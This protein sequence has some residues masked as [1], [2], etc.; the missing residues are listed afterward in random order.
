[1]KKEGNRK[2]R[3][4]SKVL[5]TSIFQE[6]EK[7][8]ED[9]SYLEQPSF[10]DV[11]PQPE[12][13]PVEEVSKE[14]ILEEQPIKK[15]EEAALVSS[16]EDSKED[17][18]PRKKKSSK[19]QPK[20]I[21][22]QEVVPTKEQEENSVPAL[23]MEV[24]KEPKEEKKKLTRR[25]KKDTKQTEPIV[26]GEEE[27]ETEK[28][29]L[30]EV[31]PEVSLLESPLPKEKK[32]PA[33]R[34][35][36][37]KKELEQTVVIEDPKSEAIPEIISVP[38]EPKI[39]KPIL[40]PLETHFEPAMQ[41][42]VIEET[43]VK[44]KKSSKKSK[45]AKKE[46]LIQPEVMEPV[47]E[48]QVLSSESSLGVL[49][50][51][52]EA[53]VQPETKIKK[54]SSKRSRKDSQPTV[55]TE[56]PKQEELEDS[57]ASSEPKL[58]KS[59]LEV[60]PEAESTV[61]TIPEVKP[62]KRQKK[63]K[64]DITPETKETPVLQE[65]VTSPSEKKEESKEENPKSFSFSKLLERVEEGLQRLEREEQEKEQQL[66]QLEEQNTKNSEDTPLNE[67]P[68]DDEIE[69]L[70]VTENKESE[71]VF[72]AVKEIKQEPSP[73]EDD[74]EILE[75]E[76]E[77]N[78]EIPKEPIPEVEVLE[79]SFSPKENKDLP[80]EKET[81]SVK[82]MV[83][84]SVIPKKV[85]KKEKKHYIT[86]IFLFLLLLFVIFLPQ[87]SEMIK[88]QTREEKVTSSSTPKKTGY[89][90][91][92]NEKSLDDGTYQVAMNVYYVNNQL[93]KITGR[94]VTT[95]TSTPVVTNLNTLQMSCL[96]YQVAMGEDGTVNCI[97]QENSQTTEAVY[98]YSKLDVAKVDKNLVEMNGMYLDYPL[99]TEISKVVNDFQKGGYTCRSMK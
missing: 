58:E 44:P 33:K 59:N 50:G 7:I 22:T 53:K 39:E 14:V 43:V 74:I 41:E 60:L 19:K 52:E 51:L 73:I 61:E 84:D 47:L 86:W 10:L 40:E 12:I 78:V 62:K 5:A 68:P 21:S 66:K 4:K 45:R 24:S 18:K 34:T 69:L 15:V 17:L 90:H 98:D 27:Q 87:I 96:S 79:E 16:L 2:L 54:K 46:E 83:T 94:Q 32:K 85:E 28:S 48:E 42:E 13:L 29:S 6:A 49:G 38:F 81:S 56:E 67:M 99:K 80:L 3:K 57:I 88:N 26:A 23:E 36:K 11:I 76:E 89:Y 82:A 72:E 1:M 92:T 64:K 35:K 55:V 25:S 91:C 71:R 37:A 95:L 8:L 20:E 77:P 31:Q 97:V 63:V 65:E 30:E 70:E 75:I 9:E 93:T